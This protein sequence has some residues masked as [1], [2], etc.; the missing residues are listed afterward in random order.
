MPPLVTAISGEDMRRHLDYAG[1][2]Q[3]N[4]FVH[5]S[6]RRLKGTC[7]NITFVKVFS[8][9]FQFTDPLLSYSKQDIGR[10]SEAKGVARCVG[11][12]MRT[13]AMQAQEESA[14]VAMVATAARGNDT[15]AGSVAGG[16]EQHGRGGRGGTR[17]GRGGRQDQRRGIARIEDE[18]GRAQQRHAASCMST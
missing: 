12:R 6:N 10:V 15:A 17:G 4:G 13:R 14:A 2:N 8:C 11:T 18:E 7:I 9:Y 5:K 1:P 3:G 16:D